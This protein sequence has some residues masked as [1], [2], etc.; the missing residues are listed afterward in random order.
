MALLP[1]RALI[2]KRFL[3]E[4]PQVVRIVIAAIV[5]WE[6]CK[7][8]DTSTVPVFA[9]VAPLIAMRD[10]PFSSLNLSFDRL[11]GVIGGVLLGIVVVAVIGVNLLSLLVVLVVGLLAGIVLRLS[12]TLNIQV[13]LTGLLVFT[14]SD[15]GS[16]GL[17][18]LWETLIGAA[19]TVVLSPFLFPPDVVKLYRA[20]F[21]RVSQRLGEHTSTAAALVVDGSRHHEALVSLV[22]EVRTTDA[23]AAALPVTLEASRQAVRNNPL[24]R[25]RIGELDEL[26]EV[27]GTVVDTGRW[28]R[29]LA[30][31][32]AD[33]SGRPD[34]DRLWP[35]TG[36]WLSRLLRPIAAVMNAALV[37]GA[38]ETAEQAAMSEALEALV[39][40][41]QATRDPIDVIL[42]RS[43]FRLVRTVSRVVGEEIVLPPWTPVHEH[44]TDEGAPSEPDHRYP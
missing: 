12:P 31:E 35:T 42:R 27:T 25:R 30:E 26:V 44:V 14:S 23:S 32:L 9:V 28:L 41:R 33:L 34:I 22:D 17:T 7:L 15:P 43:S 16:Y 36:T 4:W 39:Q 6:I 2:R 8:I 3:A 24:R 38:T 11:I 5:S 29:L 10:Q 21:R 13:A 19:V 18:R 40:W 20:E 37:R 1:D